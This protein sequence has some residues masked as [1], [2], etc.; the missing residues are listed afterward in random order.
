MSESDPASFSQVYL[1]LTFDD[2]PNRGT[3]EVL[4]ILASHNVKGT[5]FINGKKIQEKNDP[6]FNALIS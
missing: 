1:Y 4:D 3:N 6:Y 5:F 2:G